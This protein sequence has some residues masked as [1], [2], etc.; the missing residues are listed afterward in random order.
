MFEF[1][2]LIVCYIIASHVWVTSIKDHYPTLD[3]TLF[4]KIISWPMRI[5]AQ[6]L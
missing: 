4:D 5:I 3:N 2:F 6:W 1:L